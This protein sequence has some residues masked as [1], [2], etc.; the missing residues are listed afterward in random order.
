MSNRRRGQYFRPPNLPKK[1]KRG[2]EPIGTPGPNKVLKQD[3]PKRERAAPKKG[4][5][6]ALPPVQKEVRP[7]SPPPPSIVEKFTTVVKKGAKG[8]GSTEEKDVKKPISFSA[9]PKTPPTT[10]GRGKN[11]LLLPR[12][13]PIVNQSPP[14]EKRRRRVPRAPQP[15]TMSQEAAERGQ[16]NAQVLAEARH[17]INRSE[18]PT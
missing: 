2:M 9:I 17:N 4:A 12:R 6:Q 3:L 18:S 15:S 14:R 7:L 13:A 16:T 5:T 1:G 11:P 8:K 10:N